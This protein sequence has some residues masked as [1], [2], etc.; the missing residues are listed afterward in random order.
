MQSGQQQML[1][2]IT[3]L[4][5]LYMLVESSHLTNAGVYRSGKK[6]TCGKPP[7]TSG[8][9]CHSGRQSRTRHSVHCRQGCQ[10]CPNG[11][12]NGWFWDEC[13]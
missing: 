8:S 11:W 2:V 7:V 10:H 5:V 6:I 12:S 1:L 3:V 9:E 13:L 4:T